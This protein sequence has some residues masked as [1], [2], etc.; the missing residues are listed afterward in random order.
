VFPE[1][2]EHLEVLEFRNF[3]LLQKVLDFPVNLEILE[4]LE[5][6]EFLDLL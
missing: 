6:L 4:V 1:Y 2:L 3:L 5:I